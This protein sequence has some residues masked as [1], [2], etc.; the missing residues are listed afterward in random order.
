MEEEDGPVIIV[1]IMGAAEGL[2]FESF[3]LSFCIFCLD[4]LQFLEN[5]S[6]FIWAYTLK[7]IAE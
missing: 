1:I 7:D 6:S 3:E 2:P 5:K 4:F